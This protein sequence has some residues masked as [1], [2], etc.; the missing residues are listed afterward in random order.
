MVTITVNTQSQPI[1][2]SKIT[3]F[4]EE[5]H[6]SSSMTIASTAMT[7]VVQYANPIIVEL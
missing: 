3:I 1:T 5:I 2:A 4:I 6:G 7:H